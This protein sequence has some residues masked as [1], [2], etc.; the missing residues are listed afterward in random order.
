MIS[1]TPCQHQPLY[2]S[3]TLLEN[4]CVGLIETS[5]TQKVFECRAKTLGAKKNYI[6]KTALQN[7]FFSKSKQKK[8]PKPNPK[9]IKTPT[10]NKN[11]KPNKQKKSQKKT[12]TKTTKTPPNFKLYSVYNKTSEC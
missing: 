10:N 7:I 9:P 5:H 1:R 2:D 12:K 11:N 8:T 6:N 3:V 4:K